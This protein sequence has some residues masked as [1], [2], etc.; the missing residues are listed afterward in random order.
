[1][2]EI[3]LRSRLAVSC[4]GRRCSAGLSALRS[5]KTTESLSTT[6]WV[7]SSEFYESI[8]NSFP[9]VLAPQRKVEAKF[10]KL[11]HDK[12]V[13]RS[14]DDDNG[15]SHIRSVDVAA[16]LADYKQMNADGKLQDACT[17]QFYFA[18]LMITLGGVRAL[19]RTSAQLFFIALFPSFCSADFISMMVCEHTA[20]LGNVWKAFPGLQSW[21]RVRFSNAAPGATPRKPGLRS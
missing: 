11:T 8:L 13:I 17:F 6:W 14:G 12:H 21:T 1:M 7:T 4:K 19:V 16:Q 20:F 18:H 9:P 3:R 5:A 10:L 2:I 15:H